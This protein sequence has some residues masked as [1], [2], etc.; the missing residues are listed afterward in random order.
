MKKQKD[1]WQA[2]E[3]EQKLYNELKLDNSIDYN[4][5]YLYSIIAHSTAIEGSTLS[6]MDVN[7]LFDEGITK[8]GNIVEY[9]MNLDLKKAYEYAIEEARRKTRITPEFLKQLNAFAMQN[10]G[11]LY[12][13]P[14][15][16]FDSGKG[17]YRLCGVTAGAG[18]KSYPN[19]SK[20]SESVHK[21]CVKLDGMSEPETLKDRYNL[22]FD[23]HFNLVSIHPWIDG[24]GRTSRL[25]MNYMQFY[26]GMLPTKLHKEDKGEYIKALV[27]GREQDSN[28]PFREFMAKQHLKTLKEEIRNFRK[29]QDESN[30]FTLLF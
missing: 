16:T 24:N 21:L 11:G 5:F 1:I 3:Q 17:D 4:K 14:A 2:I 6:E 30:R 23:A 9:L 18:G 27:T 10:T 12:S 29:S 26:Y 19:Y 28:A 8:K 15:G 13:M 20:I 25:L 22:S 7:L